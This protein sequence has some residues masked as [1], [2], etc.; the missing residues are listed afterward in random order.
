MIKAQPRGTDGSLLATGSFLFD[1]KARLY[2]VNTTTGTA[3]LTATLSDATSV[4]E[5]VQGGD[6]RQIAAIAANSRHC[7][8]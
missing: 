1:N 2:K 6:S 4:V 3:T 5:S 7:R 8:Q